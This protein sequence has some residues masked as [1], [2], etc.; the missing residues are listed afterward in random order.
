MVGPHVQQVSEYLLFV[1]FCLR[2]QNKFEIWRKKYF[3]SPHIANVGFFGA[4][5]ITEVYSH[6]NYTCTRVHPWEKKKKSAV[7][8]RKLY[9]TTPMSS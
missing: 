2:K 9:L 1:P 7:N 3:F 8:K 5:G 4:K 6:W